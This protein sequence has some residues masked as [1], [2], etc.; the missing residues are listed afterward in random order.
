MFEEDA[1]ASTVLWGQDALPLSC[2]PIVRNGEFELLIETLVSWLDAV[3]PEIRKQDQFIKKIHYIQMKTY[4]C[5][6]FPLSADIVYCFVLIWYY[7]CNA[8]CL[9]LL[10]MAMV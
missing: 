10:L 4:V 2:Q 8:R 1:A 7:H 5:A 3:Y 6:V 9:L